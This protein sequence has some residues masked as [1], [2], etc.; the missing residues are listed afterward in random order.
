MGGKVLVMG[1]G[2][3]IMADDGLGVMAA[4]ELIKINSWPPGV[5]ILEVGTSVFNY[6]EDI[7]KARK[8]IA[9]DAITA[10]HPPGTIYRIEDFHGFEDTALF[11]DSHG[12]SLPEAVALSRLLTGMPASITVFGIEPESCDVGIGLTREIR[13]SLAKLMPLVERE[14]HISCVA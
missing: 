1:L 6:I 12:I 8:L 4:R 2:N 14:I 7:S 13:E 11:I 9:I 10:G 3:T 5:R